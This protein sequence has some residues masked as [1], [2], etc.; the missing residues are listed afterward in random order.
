[1]YLVS[2]LTLPFAA[3]LFLALWLTGWPP[4]AQVAVGIPVIVLFSAVALSASR[5]LWAAVE[6]MTD[7]RSGET[8]RPDYEARAFRR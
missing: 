4:A 6:Y 7:V 3:L 2:V 8:R 5:G 1:M